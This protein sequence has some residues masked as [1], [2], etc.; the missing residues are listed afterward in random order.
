MTAQVK[1]LFSL[2]I[3][4]AAFFAGFFVRGVMANSAQAKV[5]NQALQQAL[6]Q[7][8]DYQDQV[9]ARDNANIALQRKLTQNDQDHVNALQ[10]A[11]DQNAALRHDAAVGER[12]RLKGASCPRV[13]AGAETGTAGGLGD[14]AQVDLTE[15]TRLAVFDLREAIIRDQ[16]ALE[17]CQAYVRE[18]G[19]YP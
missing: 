19:L 9:T 13:P 2:L 7:V 16:A 14:G 15:T 5:E 11:L 6:E 4:L 18:V 10:A 3:L 17:A 1:L 12:L 8:A